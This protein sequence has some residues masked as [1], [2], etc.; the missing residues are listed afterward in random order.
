MRENLHFLVHLQRLTWEVLSVGC[1]GTSLDVMG[2][3]CSSCIL[4]AS[5]RVKWRIFMSLLV[6]MTSLMKDA[7]RF[8]LLTIIKFI[9]LTQGLA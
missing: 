5:C 8:N 9:F 4:D 1:V 2:V 7:A 6:F 3:K